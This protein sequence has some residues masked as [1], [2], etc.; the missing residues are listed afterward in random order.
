[1][2]RFTH[3]QPRLCSLSPHPP[4]PAPPCLRVKSR[5]KGCHKTKPLY[6]ICTRPG[7]TYTPLVAQTHCDAYTSDDKWI[8]LYT[9][10]VVTHQ[11][12]L[13]TAQILSFL[14]ASPEEG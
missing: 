12:P 9:R 1:M 14:E 3:V 5:K 7:H 13:K 2:H 4:T 6:V 8:L 11:G 10:T